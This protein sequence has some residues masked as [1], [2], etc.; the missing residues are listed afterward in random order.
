MTLSEPM[1]SPANALPLTERID[2]FQRKHPEI[3]ITAP[4]SAGGKWEVSE[5]DSAVVVA[6][7]RGVDMMDEEV[8]IALVG[9]DKKA[10]GDVCYASAAARGEALVD[11]L[12]HQKGS[13]E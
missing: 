1:T 3:K 9:F 5:P 10:I 6:Y 12:L 13:T 7:D 8:V 2:R 11:A 4:W